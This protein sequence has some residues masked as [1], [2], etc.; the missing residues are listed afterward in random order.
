LH[1]LDIISHAYNGFNLVLGNWED[2]WYYSNQTKKITRLGSGIYGLSNALLDTP[3]PKVARAKNRIG[4]AMQKDSI[5]SEEILDL[6]YDNQ[7]APVEALPDTGVGQEREKLLSPIFIK[8]ENYGT[9]CSTLLAIDIDGNVSFK[10]RTYNTKT[11]A[12]ES[13]EFEFELMK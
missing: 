13:R 5:S 4:E 8:S 10:E 6:L 11:F 2:L 12:S 1:N 9:R 7:E 3:W